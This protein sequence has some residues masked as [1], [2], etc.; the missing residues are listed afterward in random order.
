MAAT[1]ILTQLLARYTPLITR[2]SSP[3]TGRLYL[4]TILPIGLLYT[5]SLVCS[6][7]SYTSLPLPNTEML[8]ALAPLFTLLISWV[9]SLTNPKVSV[10]GNMV[11]IALGA[12]VTTFGEMSFV[13]RGF[14]VCVLGKAA[15]CGRL[16]I[17]EKL[18]KEPRRG[19]F[20]GAG[21]PV[22]LDEEDGEGEP[23][24]T[25]GGMGMSPLVALYYFAPVCMFLS[26]SLALAFE[27]RTF[28]MLEVQRVGTWTLALSCFL[29]FMLNVAGVFLISKTSA[30]AVSL[31]GFLNSPIPI[32]A[33]LLFSHTPI[34]FTQIMGYGFSLAGTF[35]YGLSPEGM[36]AQVDA[37][38]GIPLGSDSEAGSRESTA[39]IMA[40][41][42]EYLGSL[43]TINAQD[44]DEEAQRGRTGRR[45]GTPRPNP[46]AEKVRISVD[47]AAS[48]GEPPSGKIAGRL[49]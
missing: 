27:L 40:K 24:S 36:G 21:T 37:W 46:P 12:C 49:D 38:F 6:N 14:L 19:R 23:V 13:G 26:G 28:S 17:V 15:E 44:G 1:T 32:L 3:I 34:T 48:K 4:R 10:L 42:S 18:L 20:P 33:S 47:S 8:K 29:A 11:V 30:L 2:P 9:V 25:G 31:L 43:I 7:V 39:P 5:L 35:F 16:L 45:D 22:M 41:A